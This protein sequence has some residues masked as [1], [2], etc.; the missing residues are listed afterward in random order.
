MPAKNTKL[1]TQLLLTI[2]IITLYLSFMDIATTVLEMFTYTN[3]WDENGINYE[4][5][6]V[7]D[8]NINFDAFYHKVYIL[9]IGLPLLLVIV[10]FP[11]W[12]IG[13]F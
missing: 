3:L 10:A 8:F 6:L 12:L 13:Y 2:V 4:N 11:I 1:K 7:F 5:R 9:T